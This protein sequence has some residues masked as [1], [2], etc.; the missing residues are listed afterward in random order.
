MMES[1]GGSN[2]P[3]VLKGNG[4]VSPND[5]MQMP[6]G[7]DITNQTQADIREVPHKTPTTTG[8]SGD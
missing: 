2:I 4:S 7:Q 1:N 5:T 8:Y 3:R 6:P